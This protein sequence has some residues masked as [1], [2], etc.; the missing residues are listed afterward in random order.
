MENKPQMPDRM[1]FVKVA[2]GDSSSSGGRRLVLKNH[3]F[4]VTLVV[5]YAE[6]YPEVGIQ[7]FSCAELPHY[8]WNNYEAMRK[9]YAEKVATK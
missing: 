4:G 3:D 5:T 1:E 7:S 8:T 9:T 6:P 2:K